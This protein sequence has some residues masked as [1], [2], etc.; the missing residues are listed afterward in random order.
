MAENKLTA[1]QRLFIEEYLVSWNASDAARRAGYKSAVNVVGSRLLANVSIQE[2][3]SKRMSEKAMK[4]DENIQRLSD[5]ARINISEFI[6]EKTRYVYDKEGNQIGEYQSFELDWEQ[7]KLKGHLIKSITNTQ[8]GPRL[9]LYDGQTA[10]VQI[11]KALG[12]LTERVDM[13][14]QGEKIN[15][16]VYMPDNKRD[17][18][19]NSND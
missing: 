17:D 8:W 12:A 6:T 19:S 10:L 4:A 3:I 15:L 11:G 13:T 5:Q 1:R 18:N 14:S 9:E 7:V 16:V 2:V